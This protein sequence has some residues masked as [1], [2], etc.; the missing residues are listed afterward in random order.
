MTIATKSWIV[1]NL[2]TKAIIGYSFL[3]YNTD[4]RKPYKYEGRKDMVFKYLY[5]IKSHRG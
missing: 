1:F 5:K 4:T 3:Y 2:K